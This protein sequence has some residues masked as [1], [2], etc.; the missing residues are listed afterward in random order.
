MYTQHFG[1]HNII[2]V[3]VESILGDDDQPLNSDNMLLALCSPSNSFQNLPKGKLLRMEM[4]ME[5]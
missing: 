2:D 1:P 5:M 4:M 3:D